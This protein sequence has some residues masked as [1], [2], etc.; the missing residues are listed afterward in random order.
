MIFEN[1]ISLFDIVLSVIGIV[2]FLWTVYFA[3]RTERRNRY[4]REKQLRKIAR[5]T[6]DALKAQ[7]GAEDQP[8]R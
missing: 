5:S 3:R 6:S 1:Y 7:R 4:D 8:R 2:A